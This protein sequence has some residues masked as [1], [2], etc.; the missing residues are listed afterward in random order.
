MT[1]F[2]FYCPACGESTPCTDLDTYELA[3]GQE[4]LQCPNCGQWFVVKH[5]FEPTEQQT[6]AYWQ[7]D[8][9]G[10]RE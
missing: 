7:A 2:S 1:V 4:H 3:P 6:G 9:R 8:A 5:E 10:Q